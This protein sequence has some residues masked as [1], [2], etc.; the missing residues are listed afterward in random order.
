MLVFGAALEIQSIKND[1]NEDLINRFSEIYSY[2]YIIIK[3][4][5]LFDIKGSGYILSN[6]FEILSISNKIKFDINEYLSI[7]AFYKENTETQLFKFVKKLNNII[8]LLINENYY[9]KNKKIKSFI[10]A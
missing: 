7:L 9:F 4:F 2:L 8:P 1:I 6:F 5:L 3:K 10:N